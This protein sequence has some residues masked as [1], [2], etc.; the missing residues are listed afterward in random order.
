MTLQLVDTSVWVDWFRG[1]D[2]SAS[3]LVHELAADPTSIATTQP[4]VMELR[5]G[6]SAAQLAVVEDVVSRMVLL[7]VDPDLDFLVAADLYRAV[8]VRGDTPR[9]MVDCLIAAVALRY[10]A[11]LVHRDRDY[12]RI[13]AAAPRLTLRSVGPG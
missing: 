9:S 10:D 5:A 2:S 6:A 1:V 13:G 12:A 3:R 7:G 11:V 4:V 8:R